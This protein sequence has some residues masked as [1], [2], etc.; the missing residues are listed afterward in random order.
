MRKL[1]RACCGPARVVRRNADVD[2][3]HKAEHEEEEELNGGRIANV[4][5]RLFGV[6]LSL[7]V[8]QQHEE[9][10]ADARYDLAL[11]P[12]RDKPGRRCQG[13]ASEAHSA[14]TRGRQ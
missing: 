5:I 14:R 11:R 6:G 9:R 2:F 3:Q 10:D 7:L 4:A 13:L 8:A 1:L 12:G